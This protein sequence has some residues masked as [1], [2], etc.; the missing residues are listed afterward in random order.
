MREAAYEIARQQ[1]GFGDST[2]VALVRRASESVARWAQRRAALAH[3]SKLDDHLLRDVGLSRA[4]L[5]RLGVWAV[6][7]SGLGECRWGR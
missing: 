6:T 2:L 1:A 4:E 5:D 3:L 7:R